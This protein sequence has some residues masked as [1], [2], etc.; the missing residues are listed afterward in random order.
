MDMDRFSLKKLNEGEVKELPGYNQ[1]Q[2][3]SSGELRR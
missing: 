3:F 2:I 1:E